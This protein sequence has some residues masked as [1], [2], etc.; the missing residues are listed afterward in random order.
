MAK[1]RCVIVP[2]HRSIGNTLDD[3]VCGNVKRMR[4]PLVEDRNRDIRGVELQ[5]VP[6]VGGHT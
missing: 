1:V 4:R 2:I 3:S 6:V 5:I